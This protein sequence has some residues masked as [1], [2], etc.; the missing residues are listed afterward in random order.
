MNLPRPR[1]HHRPS[2]HALGHH[3]ASQPTP[4]R[5]FPE[6]RQLGRG[7]DTGITRRDP[8]KPP[9]TRPHW[10]GGRPSQRSRSRNNMSQGGRVGR[11]VRVTELEQGGQSG[12]H[13]EVPAAVRRLYDSFTGAPQPITQSRTKS[14]RNAAS[15]QAAIRAVDVNHLP[16]E[17]TTLHEAL[18]SPEWPNWQRARKVEM[19]GQLARQASIRMVLSIVAVKDWEPA[20]STSTWRIWRQL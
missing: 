17:L 19:D 6:T 8:R 9:T 4:E 3:V 11:I 13:Q 10:G 1:P 15:L 18:A 2:H 20:N 14:G 12:D 7:R 5:K 16:P